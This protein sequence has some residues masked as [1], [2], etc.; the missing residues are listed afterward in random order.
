MAWE[1]GGGEGGGWGG[2]GGWE[3]GEGEEEVVRG[4]VRG[5]MFVSLSLVMSTL[6]TVRDLCV[7]TSLAIFYKED[8]QD[9]VYTYVCV[10]LHCITPAHN[11]KPQNSS[12]LETIFG[13]LKCP[14]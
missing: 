5:W 2:E 14:E 4:E 7:R 11:I 8:S 13:R 12:K 10:H 6:P 1:G 3:E 9:D